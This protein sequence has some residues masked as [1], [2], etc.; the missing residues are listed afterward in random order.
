MESV[1]HPIKVKT[2]D[3]I[4]VKLAQNEIF[5][6]AV[7]SCK[8]AAELE[9]LER[10]ASAVKND[11]KKRVD[12]V[13]VKLKE[14]RRS[15]QSG[16]E[17]REVDCYRAFDLQ[18]GVTWLEFEGEKYL[19]RPASDKEIELLQQGTLEEHMEFDDADAF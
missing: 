17:F 8:V 3:K 19:E 11:W 18:R 12:C 10:D 14:L 9:S 4:N 2:R 6:R 1:K 13:Q 5:E 15:V 16:E 7:M